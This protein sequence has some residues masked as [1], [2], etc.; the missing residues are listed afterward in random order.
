MVPARSGCP[1][2]FCAG[3]AIAHFW[4]SQQFGVWASR[5]QSAHRVCNA[6]KHLKHCRGVR[7]GNEVRPAS[8]KFNAIANAWLHASTAGAKSDQQR[9]ITIRRLRSLA[10]HHPLITKAALCVC[11]VCSRRHT[12]RSESSCG[13]RREHTRRGEFAGG[14]R[15]KHTSTSESP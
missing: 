2:L 1:D 3:A 5:R 12:C 13:L 6:R 7:R 8:T 10:I 9:A 15:R 4:A 11:A 14:L